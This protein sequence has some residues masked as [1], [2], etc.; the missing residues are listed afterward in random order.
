MKVFI[1]DGLK[2]ASFCK[3]AISH[4]VPGFE[5]HTVDGIANLYHTGKN[6]ASGVLATVS[7]SQFTFLQGYYKV[8]GADPFPLGP[9]LTTFLSRRPSSLTPETRVDSWEE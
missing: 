1:F 2:K 5:I 8:R 9:D 7:S 4:I 6:K 3:D